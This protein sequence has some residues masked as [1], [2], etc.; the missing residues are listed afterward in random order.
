MQKKSISC[1]RTWIPKH[2][3]VFVI[4]YISIW[5]FHVSSVGYISRNYIYIFEEPKEYLPFPLQ[6]ILLM[7]EHASNKTKLQP[8]QVKARFMVKEQFVQGNLMVSIFLSTI[9]PFLEKCI[10]INYKPSV[11]PFGIFLV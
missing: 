7:I 11:S 2:G 6:N 10:S 4:K 1:H 5:L 8:P 3:H 9:F